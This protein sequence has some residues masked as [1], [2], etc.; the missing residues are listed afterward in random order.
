MIVPLHNHSE[1]STLDGL[2]TVREI[3]ERCVELGCECC[4]LT[5][6]GVVSGHLDFGKTLQKYGIKPIYGCELYHGLTPG[7]PQ[8]KGQVRDQFHFVVGAKTDEGLRNL[9]RLVSQA[10]TNYHYVARATW[11]MI[12]K[13]SEGLFATS[14]CL[15]GLVTKGIQEDDHSYLDKYLNIFGDDFYIELHTYPTAHQMEIN[16]A[17]VR[18]AQERGVGLVYANDAHYAFPEQYEYH[19]AYVAMSTGQGIDTPFEDRKM[20]HPAALYMMGEEEIRGS[21]N[22]LPDSVVDEALENSVLIASQ[23]NAEL[24]EVKRHLPAFIPKESA[25]VQAEKKD[26]GAAE[27]FLD[28][29]EM[30]LYD[31]YGEDAPDEVWDRAQ[32]E[33][34]VFLSAGLEHYFLQ[35][36]D[37]CQ[38]CDQNGIKRGPGR[39]SA[40]GAIVAYALGITDI[41]PLHYDL[42]FERFFNPGR[43]KGFPDID[44]DFPKASRKVVRDYLKRRWGADKVRTI[45]TITR[46]KPKAVCDKTYNACGVTWGEKEAIKK[47]ID[48]VPDIDIL[49]PDSIG[50]SED[51]D[52]GKTIYV[53]DHVGQEIAEWIAEQQSSR[54]DFLWR[55]IDFCDAICSRISG[56]GV[57]PS[58]VVVAE[59]ELDPELP[60]MWSAAQEELVTQFAM[61]DVDNRMFV[62]QDLLGLRTLDTLEEW[63][64][65]VGEKVEWSGLE[66]REQFPDEMWEFFDR[67]LTL[68]IFQIEDGYARKLCERFK[69]RSIEDLSIIV[70]LNRP[71]PIRSGAPDSFIIRR[72]G[73]EDNKFD[74]RKY[75]FLNGLLDETYGWFLYQEQVIQ[76]FSLLG[77]DLSDADAV[78]KILGKKKPEEMLALKNGTGEWEG[79]GYFEMFEK[80]IE[81]YSNQTGDWQWGDVATTIFEKIED[82]AKYSFNKSH[83]VAYA[84]IA[85]RCVYAKW[86]NTPAMTM[87][88]I[89]TNADMAGDYVAEA[90]RMAI[91]VRPPDIQRSQAEIGYSDDDAIY[92]G[93]SNVKGIGIDS[94]HY[95]VELRDE[96]AITSP[97]DLGT[98]LVVATKEHEA[99]K[100]QAKKDGVDFDAKS[101]KQK[102]RANCVTALEAAGGF[103]AYHPRS[104]TMADR[105][106]LEKEYLGVVLTDDTQ[107]AFNNNMDLIEECDDYQDM[108]NTDTMATYKLAG[109]I[110]RVKETKTKA[111]GNKMGIVKIEFNGDE[112]EFVV[113]P[114]DWLKFNFLW[115]ERT[116]GIFDIA[117]TERGYNFKN[118]LKLN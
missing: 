28:L 96:N 53:M 52:P 54:R 6:H 118:G 8:G 14:A 60:A 58:G 115:R 93:F 18:L 35:A 20:W 57:H 39:G 40:A 23:C 66:F 27:L 103:D 97:D 85:F 24:P 38:F 79:K 67:G 101:P 41:E 94:A 75:K 43:A 45:G 13:Y 51:T 116:A 22:Y 107:R 117:R 56:Y 83:S 108:L 19:D 44:N 84:T 5:D 81:R 59:V 102:F 91:E 105:Q 109:V 12:D 10:S 37:F 36:W 47:I 63:E 64:A 31:R 82:F 98:A 61:G 78:R 3:A 11:D 86:K 92:F 4:G 72:Q 42:I 73:G 76:F 100:K 49:G 16:E 65:I 71:G 17:L 74:G 90:R 68:G 95:L 29:V 87:A 111:S 15:A 99:K 46:L 25:Y 89:K 80:F 33:M 55:W 26:M 62:K 88:L 112:A 48:G 70:A 106:K 32:R 114:Q 21:L 30:G 2:S 50:W 77:Y 69:P 1:Y 7:K 34:E 9:W 104:L 113:F 110:T